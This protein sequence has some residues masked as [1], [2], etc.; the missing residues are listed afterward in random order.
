MKGFCNVGLIAFY[1]RTEMERLM[2]P[3]GTLF[4]WFISFVAH[5]FGGKTRIDI[6]KSNGDLY[7]NKYALAKTNDKFPCKKI[8][9][10]VR[11]LKG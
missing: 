9:V 10:Y 7:E 11:R 4:H 5:I 3:K 6:S 8:I 2:C 1:S